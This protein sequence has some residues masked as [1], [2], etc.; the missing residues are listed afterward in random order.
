MTR[1]LVVEDNFENLELVRCLLEFK[2]YPSEPAMD[3]ERAL[4]LANK[5]IFDLIL[6][7][8]Q[9][10]KIDGFEVIRRL[11]ETINSNTPIIAVTAC[12]MKGDEKKLLSQGCA[13]Y[14]AKPFGVTQFYDAISLCL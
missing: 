7:D 3:G 5:Y 11:K 13:H 10:P 9:L 6:L 1:V 8:I 4:E 2:G 12:A 14:L